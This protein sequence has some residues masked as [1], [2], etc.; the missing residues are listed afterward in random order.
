[1]ADPNRGR[2]T[3]KGPPYSSLFF[4]HLLILRPPLLTGGSLPSGENDGTRNGVCVVRV[5][6]KYVLEF[7]GHVRFTKFGASGQVE[8]SGS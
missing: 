3:N 1:M 7:E 8:K 5:P 4:L 2:R 6:D